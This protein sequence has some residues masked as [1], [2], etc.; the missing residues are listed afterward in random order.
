MLKK[1]PSQ[2]LQLANK[3]FLSKEPRYGG[4]SDT[5]AKL[6]SVDFANVVKLAE[7]EP[8]ADAETRAQV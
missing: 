1:R 3:E 2:V 7:N 6:F 5:V 8:P 4:G